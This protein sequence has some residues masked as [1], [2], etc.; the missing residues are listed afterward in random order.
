[1][2]IQTLQCD[3]QIIWYGSTDIIVAKISTLGK[4]RSI[5]NQVNNSVN[6]RGN[7]Q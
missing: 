7:H 3:W 2:G 6:S 4:P 5:K 1:M